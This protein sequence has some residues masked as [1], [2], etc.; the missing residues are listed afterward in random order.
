MEAEPYS[1]V[2]DTRLIGNLPQAG[3][4]SPQAQYFVVID[5]PP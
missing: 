3:S 1:P 5:N 2:P 4:L